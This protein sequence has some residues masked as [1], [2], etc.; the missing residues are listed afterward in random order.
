DWLRDTALCHVRLLGL[1]CS[2][3]SAGLATAATPFNVVPPEPPRVYLS[4]ARFVKL[5]ALERRYSAPL[6]SAPLSLRKTFLVPGDR[7]HTTDIFVHGPELTLEADPVLVAANP[8]VSSRL[9]AGSLAAASCSPPSRWP[10]CRC[11]SR[12][13]TGVFRPDGTFARALVPPGL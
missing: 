10:A 4:V 6:R 9:A 8:I 7:N 5:Y 11:S 2:R 13:A 1:F 12:L 3:S